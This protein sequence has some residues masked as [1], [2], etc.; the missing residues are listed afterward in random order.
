MILHIVNDFNLTKVHKELYY[1]LDELGI[2]QKIFI[3]FRNNSQIGN[4]HF[5]F[6]TNGSDYIYSDRISLLHR[7]IFPFK[8]KRLY[9][10]L[11][12]KVE[13]DKITLSHATTLFSDG[14][15]A[16]KLY[17]KYNIPYIVAVRNTD[18]NF[19]FTKRKELINLGLNILK[20]ASKIIFISESNKDN[21]LKIKSIYKIKEDIIHKIVVINNGIDNYW[22]QN[23][24]KYKSD[25][26]QDLNFLF[27]GRFDS[28]KNVENLIAA[29]QLLNENRER[30][31]RLNLVGGTGNNHNKVIDLITSIDWVNYHGEI[32]DK[33]LLEVIFQENDYFSMISHTETFGLV[34]IEALSQG[35]PLLYTK[36]QGVD[37]VFNIQ[38]GESVDSKNI[39]DIKN[40]IETLISNTYEEINE[41]HFSSFSWKSISEKYSLIYNDII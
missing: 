15:I 20:N 26:K 17:K 30:K 40:K 7:V 6:V 19:Y 27:I 37:G 2:P 21:F 24:K 38:I 41:I 33:K 12:K 18:I 35:K 16:Y 5:E 3:P 4:N 11:I 1:N 28:N 34:Y 25:V 29:F 23:R 36:G 22:I 8:I 10:S 32:Y 13:L 39:L 14:A 9:N 31:L